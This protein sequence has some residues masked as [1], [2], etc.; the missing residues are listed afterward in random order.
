MMKNNTALHLCVIAG[1]ILLA[2]QLSLFALLMYPY[3][4]HS[5]LPLD[6]I[7]GIVNITSKLHLSLLAI[8]NHILHQY[9]NHRNDKNVCIL[10]DATYPLTFAVLFRGLKHNEN[11]LSMFEEAGYKT[12]LMYNSNPTESPQGLAPNIPLCYL[13]KRKVV[14]HLVLFHERE[15]NF[16][17]H[18]DV[19]SDPDAMDHLSLL[20]LSIHKLQLMKH[21]GAFEKFESEQA[22]IDNIPFL[23]PKDIVSF[24]RDAASS[25]YIECSHKTADI[26]HK[27]FGKDTTHEA[28]KFKHRAWKLLSRA[29]TLLDKLGVRFWLSSGTCLGY[30][31]QCDIIPYSRDVDIGIFIT[32]YNEQIL[33]E[34]IA[35]GFTL[36][37]WFGRVNDSL[38]LSFMSNDIKLDIFFFY[39]EDYWV[40]NGGTQARTGKKFKYKFPRFSLCWTEFLELKVRVPCELR[41]YI[42]ANYGSEWFTPVSQWDW[43]SSPPNVQENGVWHRE[44]WPHVIQVYN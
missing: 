20:G 6:D 15:G 4:K 33:S 22:A 35:H 13:L 16:W 44:E 7:M 9:L 36:K 5:V 42:E 25:R 10:C 11:L 23:I 1:L 31:R 32:D 30:F 29:K 39:E 21:E 38:E 27:K 12:F 34:F 24:L 41:A 8:D 43:K 2:A 17:W 26:F 37:H 19:H 18:G 28:L 14:V 3:N 40:W